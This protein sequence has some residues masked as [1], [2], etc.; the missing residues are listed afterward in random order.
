MDMSHFPFVH[1][2]TIGTPEAELVE[3]F[4]VERTGWGMTVAGRHPFPNHNDPG[5]A[6]GERPLLQHRIVTFTYAPPFTA[7]LRIDY[8][9]AGGTNVILL[10][11]QPVDDDHARVYF[12]ILRDDLDGQ[13]ARMAACLADED[14]ISSEDL[15]LQE[16]FP[17]KS[18]PLDLTTEVHVRADRAGIELRRILGDLVTAP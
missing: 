5:V 12:S 15:L 14:Q 10:T 6:S 1:A 9:E 16:H 17:D 8:Q 3:E 4:V 18:I 13:A 2:A 11:V 7:R